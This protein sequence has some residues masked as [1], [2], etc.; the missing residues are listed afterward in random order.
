MGTQTQIHSAN[1]AIEST[2]SQPEDAASD[3]IQSQ[4]RIAHATRNPLL[5]AAISGLLRSLLLRDI[6][7]VVIGI[8]VLVY[9]AD[10]L[11]DSATFIARYFGVSEL[12]IGL[13]LVALGTSL[14]ELAASVVAILYKRGDIALGNLVGSNLFNMLAIVGITAGVRALPARSVEHAL[15]GLPRHA[16]GRNALPLLLVLRPP[17]VVNRWKGALMLTLYFAYTIG[18]FVIEQ[19]N[20][21]C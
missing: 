15:R 17:H 12:V 14:P 10:L 19:G 5:P 4:K 1:E 11:V 13:S 21:V 18:I 2:D 20:G 9:G 16:R 8:S 3:L 7:M 6:G